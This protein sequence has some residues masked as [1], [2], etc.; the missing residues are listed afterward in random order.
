MMTQTAKG[1]GWS[2]FCALLVFFLIQGTSAAYNK[3]LEIA[4]D[5]ASVYL[6]P[7]A[8]SSVIR[9]LKKGDVVTLAS[10]TKIKSQWYYIYFKLENSDF[11]SSGYIPDSA[12]KKLFSVTKIIVIDE[13]SAKTNK[14]GAGT[15]FKNIHWGMNQE[16]VMLNEGPPLD[17][18]N[19]DG[20]STLK[21]DAELMDRSCLLTY[22]FAEDNLIRAAYYLSEKYLEK[23]LN[24]EDHVSIKSILIQKYGIPKEERAFRQYLIDEGHSIKSSG[25][26]NPLPLLQATCWEN[27]ET[28]ICLNLYQNQEHIEIELEYTNLGS[29]KSGIKASQKGLPGFSHN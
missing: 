21:Y 7:D 8:G 1:R 23:T 27:K 25:A 20:S 22:F 13:G 24:S 12:V 2:V 18:E 19:T 11:T 26:H 17:R 5:K 14:Y 16:Q 29:S 4:A 9:L 6:K 3:K 10:P 15:R 28:R